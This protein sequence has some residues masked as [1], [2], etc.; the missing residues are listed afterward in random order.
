M[1]NKTAKN[2]NASTVVRNNYDNYILRNNINF[3]TPT[4]ASPARSALGLAGLS[5]CGR[6]ILFLDILVG[7]GRGVMVLLL[8]AYHC[9]EMLHLYAK[10]WQ[11]LR[12]LVTRQ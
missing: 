1:M 7:E 5:G 10:Y 9:P 3:T 6:Q 11:P 2:T 8:A 4:G 12:A